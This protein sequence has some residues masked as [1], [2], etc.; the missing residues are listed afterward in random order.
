MKLGTPDHAGH[1]G[2]C[3]TRPFLYTSFIAL[4]QP[5]VLDR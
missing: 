1:G 2:S 3:S 5:K 4:M